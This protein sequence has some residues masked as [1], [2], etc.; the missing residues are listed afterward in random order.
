[1]GRTDLSAVGVIRLVPE[2]KV[3]DLGAGRAFYVDALGF[4]VAYERPEERFVYL[5][6]AGAELMLEEIQSNDRVEVAPLER[7]F[8]RGVNLQIECPGGL[9]ELLESLDRH[10]VMPFLPL[11]DRWY[12][13]GST[14]L[15][16]RQVWIQD[17]DGYLLRFF[18][19]LGQRS[20]AGEEPHL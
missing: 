3:S 1:M 20:V 12:R 17:P 4:E 10:G 2:L 14:E 13:R 5:D 11:E 9:S 7:P 18:E 19:D 8:G 6:R 16:N 15:G